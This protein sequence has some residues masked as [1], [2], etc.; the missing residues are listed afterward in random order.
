MVLAGS[1]KHRYRIFRAVRQ[2]QRLRRR[3]KTKICDTLQAF[4]GLDLP[5]YLLRRF[6]RSDTG[7]TLRSPDSIPDD[8][9]RSANGL[10]VQRSANERRKPKPETANVVRLLPGSTLDPGIR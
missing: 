6:R 10:D 7:R 1:E 2:L 9:L 3:R 8:N 5:R 4:R